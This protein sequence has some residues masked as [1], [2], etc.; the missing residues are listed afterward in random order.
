MRTTPVLVSHNRY[1]IPPNGCFVFRW[2]FHKVLKRANRPFTLWTANMTAKAPQLFTMIVHDSSK[3]T[4]E[5]KQRTFLIFM[6]PSDKDSIISVPSQ[7]LCETKVRRVKCSWVQCA[8]Q[9]L[10][11]S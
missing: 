8:K 4:S 5:R 11:M 9:L 2:I 3:V 1:S 6:P 7:R 10:K